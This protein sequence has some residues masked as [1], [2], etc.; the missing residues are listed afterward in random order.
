MRQVIPFYK[1][2]VFKTNIA[3]I[4]SIS[5]EHEEKVFDGEISGDFIVFGDYKIH[6]DT[7][8]R[9]LFKYRLPFTAIIPDNIDKNTVSIDI[10]NFTYEQLESDVIKVNID[11]SIEGDEKKVDENNDIFDTVERLELN[12]NDDN[13]LFNDKN[14]ELVDRSIESE[15][16]DFLNN[17]SND[18]VVPKDY[19]EKEDL[20]IK[21][22]VVKDNVVED[23]LIVE[24]KN[25][26]VVDEYVTYH[27]HIVK[28]NET[29]E[30]ILKKYNVSLDFVKE[31]N[32]ITD[33]KYGDKLIIPDNFDE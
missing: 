19:S 13:E 6:N 30:M 23:D 7:T 10:D 9:E 15:I 1:E 16:D 26:N 2:I 24:E 14:D 18:V 31:Y 27:I 5:L 20:Q 8:E 11:F 25:V 28:E 32:E 22:S 17:Y 3:S 21:D 12:I 4:T 33:I 29:L